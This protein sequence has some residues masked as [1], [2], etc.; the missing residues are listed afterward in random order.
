MQSFRDTYAAAQEVKCIDDALVVMRQDRWPQWFGFNGDS[1]LCLCVD[2][3]MDG[4]LDG[5][6]D[7]SVDGVVG[8]VLVLKALV[9]QNPDSWFVRLKD[10]AKACADASLSLRV[11]C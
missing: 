2:A 9:C 4:S 11:D 7:G 3:C 6:V 5:V 8:S 10:L 1:A